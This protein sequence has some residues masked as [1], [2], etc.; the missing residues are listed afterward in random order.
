MN[1]FDVTHFAT[2]TLS[3]ALFYDEEY[4]AIGAV[5]L[6]SAELKREAYIASYSPEDD[7][8]LIEQATVWE[9]YSPDGDDDIGYQ[10]AV[11][12]NPHAS[13][14]SPMQA[15]Q[16]LLALAEEENLEPGISLLFEV[17]DAD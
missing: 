9:E 10:L 15:A 16:Q 2:V 6:V 8:Y 3:E 5:S 12:S 11:D 4:G 13:F 17:D 7:R 1:P 14:E